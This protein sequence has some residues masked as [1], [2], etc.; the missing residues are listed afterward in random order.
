MTL[1]LV[2]GSRAKPP[3]SCSQ[4]LVWP[5]LRSQEEYETLTCPEAMVL[6]SAPGLSLLWPTRK[7]AQCWGVEQGGEHRLCSPHWEAAVTQVQSESLWEQ[8]VLCCVTHGP[9]PALP[10]ESQHGAPT[11]LTFGPEGS[12]FSGRGCQ[13][14]Q[15]VLV[16]LHPD[17]CGHDSEVVMAVTFTHSFI[18]PTVF[19]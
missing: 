14:S 15:G 4:V 9:P 18:P 19:P 1:S 12:Q 6:P 3:A 8:T 17:P 10:P 16:F 11:F 13:C 2:Q 7:G 5:R